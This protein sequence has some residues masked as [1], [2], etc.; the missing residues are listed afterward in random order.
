MGLLFSLPVSTGTVVCMLD[1]AYDGLAG[2][3]TQVKGHLAAAPVA[4]T[5]ERM[6]GLL[7]WLH[8]MCTHL[9]TFYGVHAQRGR[10][11]LNDLGVLPA[12]IGTLVT[13]ALASYTVYG[14]AHALCGAN[15]LRKLIA[16]TEDTHRDPAWAGR[17]RRPRRG[18]GRGRRHV[19][20]WKGRARPGR[21][22]RVS[23]P[24]PAGR[25]ADAFSGSEIEEC[26]G[27][28]DS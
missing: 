7:H 5:N 4:H 15:V 9:V 17:D 14:D 11:A 3:E 1:R 23:G 18:Q 2:F 22:V 21:A 8:G 20:R 12:F 26:K 25:V 27:V 16:V 28:V 6:A 19:G 24:L 13:D 10:E